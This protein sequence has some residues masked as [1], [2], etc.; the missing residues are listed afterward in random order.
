MNHAQFR[1]AAVGCWIA[2]LA[3]VVAQ[4]TSSYDYTPGWMVWLGSGYWDE[5]GVGGLWAIALTTIGA[6][7]WA[8]DRRAKSG[9]NAAGFSRKKPQGEPSG[10]L[11]ALKRRARPF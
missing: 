1:I 5:E 9:D 10:L 8:G 4:A 3:I 11:G 7:A 6:I 2:A